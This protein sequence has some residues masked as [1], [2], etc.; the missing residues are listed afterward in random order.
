MKTLNNKRHRIATEKQCAMY[1]VQCTINDNGNERQ[2]KT[3]SARNDDETATTRCPTKTFGHDRRVGFTLVELVITIAIVIIL[4]VVSVPIYRGYIDKAKMSEG[5]ALLGTI[6]SAQKA[7]FS[8]YGN[9]LDDYQGSGGV[10]KFT[11]K[12]EVLGIDARGN[13]HF[14]LFYF[15]YSGNASSIGKYFFEGD[16]LIPKD[17]TTSGKNVLRMYYNIT[18][19]A[20]VKDIVAQENWSFE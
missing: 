3:T 5:Y 15:D 16:V 17:L 14:T 19:G 20:T 4:S 9:F 10:C 11:S 7:Y 1:N 8:E 18:S 6:L 13:K 2:L 12:D